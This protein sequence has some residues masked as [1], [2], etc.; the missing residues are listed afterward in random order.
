MLMLHF[1]KESMLQGNHQVKHN[2]QEGDRVYFHY[3]TLEDP[4][5]FIQYE[6]GYYIFKVPIHDIFLSVRPDLYGD[7]ISNGERKRVH[8]HNQYVLGTEYWGTGW[9]QVE[10]PDPISGVVTKIAGK[11]NSFGMVTETKDKPLEDA[12]IITDIGKGIDPY[13][14]HKEVK[15]GDAVILAPNCE[16][17]NEIEHQERWVFTHQ[18]ILGKIEKDGNVRPVADMVKIKLRP[19]KYKG[20]LVVDETKLP[21]NNDGII[22][23]VGGSVDSILFIGAEVKFASHGAR[24]LDQ[25]EHVLVHEC[26]VIGILNYSI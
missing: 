15:K 14:R 12:A 26:N 9:E 6:Q 17:K 11:V 22:V 18:D 2:I 24:V 5:N 10:V 1:R 3:L 16:F 19:R 25:E 13:S 23:D 7:Y 4:H 8:L 21:L 20:K